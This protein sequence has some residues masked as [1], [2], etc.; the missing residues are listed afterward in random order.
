MA[1]FLLIAAV[2]LAITATGHALSCTECVGAG[3]KICKG[4]SKLCPE[5]NYS[6]LLMCAVTSVGSM[7]TMS[8]NVRQCGLSSLCSKTGSLSLPNGRFRTSITCC[9]EDHCTPTTPSIPQ[10]VEGKNGMKCPA[11]FV[12]DSKSCSSVSWMNCFGGE[13]MCI[14][15]VT[16]TTGAINASTVARGCATESLCDPPRQV[17]NLGKMVVDLENTCTTSTSYGHPLCQSLMTLIISLCLFLKL[18][19]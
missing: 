6:C 12:N 10:Y 18:V 15:Q 8:M 14:T 9:D 3:D 19:Y 13:K 7:V 4:T 5:G 16:N 1:K 17:W 11:C 2:L